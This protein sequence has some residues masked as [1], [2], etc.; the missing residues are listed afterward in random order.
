MRLTGHTRVVSNSF[1][2]AEH[3][4]SYHTLTV[5]ENHRQTHHT[6]R[7]REFPQQQFFKHS[8]GTILQRLNQYCQCS[9]TAVTTCVAMS[10][11]KRTDSHVALITTDSASSSTVATMHILFIR[12]SLARLRAHET[13]T[14]GK[15]IAEEEPPSVRNR[16][17]T[18]VTMALKKGI[19]DAR[20]RRSSGGNI[21]TKTHVSPRGRN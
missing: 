6:S 15:G 4:L 2:A 8:M 12:P 21:S 3:S 11:P 18:G 7:I 20:P 9:F 14:P 17:T 1:N 19:R 5:F 10:M 13:R 16:S